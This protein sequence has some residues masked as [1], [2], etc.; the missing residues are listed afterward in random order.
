MA[1]SQGVVPFGTLNCAVLERPVLVIALAFVL[2]CSD[3]HSG[4]PSAPS[5]LGTALLLTPLVIGILSIAAANLQY[6]S[7][8]DEVQTR[9]PE[10]DRF[11]FPNG[12]WNVSEITRLHREFYPGS[13]TAARHRFLLRLGF[14]CLASSV[15]VGICY[16]FS[17]PPR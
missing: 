2:G 6:Q 10:K 9:L 1:L 15:L 4:K 16:A 7:M 12:S 14:G 8:I 3:Q 17:N 5:W 13:R 11:L